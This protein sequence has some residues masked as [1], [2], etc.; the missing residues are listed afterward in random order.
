MR[1]VILDG[2]CV[3]NNLEVWSVLKKFGDLEVYTTTDDTEICSRLKYADIAVSKRCRLRPE[4]VP[5][6][7]LFISLLATGI[8]RLDVEGLAKRSITISNIPDYCSTTLAEFT[9]ALMLNIT[10]RIGL[11]NEDV[12]AGKWINASVHDVKVHPTLELCGK[13]LGILGTGHIGQKVALLARAFGME[14]IAFSRSLSAEAQ[15]TVC[16]VDSIEEVYQRSDIIAL[17]LPLTKKTTKIINSSA[18]EKMKDGVILLN[19]SRG[20]LVDEEAVVKGLHSGKIS[21]YGADSL[22]IEPPTKNT[23]LLEEPNAFITPH[24]AWGSEESIKR[25]VNETANNIQAFLSGQPIHVVS[26]WFE[27]DT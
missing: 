5:E 13:T 7:V 25:M 19:P 18:I 9:I 12:K 10:Q 26:R 11:Y 17:H 21:A 6:N 27:G 3:G 14:V 4:V 24:I 15:K 23:G 22:S 1:I 2:G 20:L 8:D 16:Y